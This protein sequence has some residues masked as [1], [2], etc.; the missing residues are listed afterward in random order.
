MVSAWTASCTADQP[1]ACTTNLDNVGSANLSTPAQ[2]ENDSNRF[3]WTDITYLLH[4]H[5]IW[6]KYYLSQ[7]P[8]PHCGSLGADCPPVALEPNVPSIWNPLPDFDDVVADGE[9]GCIQTVDNFYQDVASGNLPQVSWIVPS[10]PVSEH[11]PAAVSDG[12]AYVTGLINAIMKSSAWPS[13]VIFLSWDDWGGFYDHVPPAQIDAEGLGFR[14]PAITI[15]PWVKAAGLVDKQVLSHDSYL[16][17]IEDVFIDG[18]RIDPRTDGRP[19][20]RPFER[21]ENTTTLGDL[22]NDF[23]FTRTPLPPLVLPL[24]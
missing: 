24:Q 7:G 5:K 20:S 16:R 17:F 19:D 8:D 6:W 12:Q 13:T 2:V 11:P 4:E 22:M 14:V 21:D 18:D 15:S 23:D 3:P 9:T 10:A 1:L